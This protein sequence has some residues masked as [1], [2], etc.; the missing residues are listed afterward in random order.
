[1]RALAGRH[2]GS[3]PPTLARGIDRA[4]SRAGFVVLLLTIGFITSGPYDFARPREAVETVPQAPALPEF[5]TPL[6]ASGGEQHAERVV[7]ER[8]VGPRGVPGPIPAVAVMAYKRAAEALNGAD[9]TCHLTWRLVAAGGWVESQHGQVDGRVLA[10]DGVA[11]PALYGEVSS[12]VDTDGA[13]LDGTASMDRTAGPF[14]IA[15]VDWAQFGV[16]GDADGQRNPQDIDDAA[17]AY[18]VLLCAG[19]GDLREQATAAARLARANA[20]AEYPG[21]VMRVAAYYA[22]HPALEAEPSSAFGVIQLD[23][24]PSPSTSASSTPAPK[25]SPTIAPAAAPKP[26]KPVPTTPTTRPTPSP[27]ATPSATAS[28]SPT[29]LASPSPSAA[30]SA[31]SPR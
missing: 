20:A 22:A 16:D 3:P 6:D 29:A 13:R 10:P 1:M 2:R 25:H 12:R 24:V 7:L 19:E 14:Q 21:E 23:P 9:P 8:R 27:S 5:R 31:P 18:G 30:A 4:I 15:P 26:S 17:L 28:S 11:V